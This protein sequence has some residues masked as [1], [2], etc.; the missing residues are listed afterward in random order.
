MKSCLTLCRPIL[1]NELAEI[2]KQN[3]MLSFH[4]KKTSKQLKTR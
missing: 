3:E 1:G 4:I 2:T